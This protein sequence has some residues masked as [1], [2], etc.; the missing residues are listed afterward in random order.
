[1]NRRTFLK[2]A[3]VLSVAGSLNQ[4]L[5]GDDEL[6]VC[7][8]ALLRQQRASLNQTIWERL[9]RELAA[10]RQLRLSES[11]LFL[12]NLK[13]H[14]DEHG[15][16]LRLQGPAVGSLVCHALGLSGVCPLDHQLL[17]ERFLDATR[18]TPLTMDFDIDPGGLHISQTIPNQLGA[19]VQVESWGLRID[20]TKRSTGQEME[21]S[22]VTL[23][24]LAVV[25]RTI[26]LIE[27]T[28]G[29]K[30]DLD[31]LHSPDLQTARLLQR[32]E[33]H[34]VYQYDDAWTRHF[35][36]FA[37]PNSVA[38]LIDIT[39]I[40]IQTRYAGMFA[41]NEAC[42]KDERLLLYQEQVMEAFQTMAGMEPVDGMRFI[43]AVFKKRSKEVRD[44]LRRFKAGVRKRGKNVVGE[45]MAD[46]VMQFGART[47]CKARLAGYASLAYQMAFLKAHFP[48]QFEA[49]HRPT[50]D[51]SGM[52]F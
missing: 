33:T 37:K 13:R 34:G 11:F 36:R 46:A 42:V 43:K 35:L 40:T 12:R 47:C 52:H 32:G 6:Q 10:I 25:R 9:E 23:P 48:G 28:H 31:R 17:F 24:A 39:A 3:S 1:M 16:M 18:K 51:T 30:P 27:R 38:D 26:Q 8:V 2:N 50:G 29:G 14:A 19:N 49:A 4:R 41:R 5:P 15:V 45:R 22:A 44:L 7:C 20:W 21:V